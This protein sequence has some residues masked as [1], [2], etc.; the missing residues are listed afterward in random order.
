MSCKARSCRYEYQRRLAVV[1]PS[2]VRAA[3]LAAQAR[4]E[5]E[6]QALLNSVG[7]SNRNGPSSSSAGMQ[8]PDGDIELA[9]MEDFRVRALVRQLRPVQHVAVA[10]MLKGSGSGTGLKERL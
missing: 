9:P 10:R 3:E 8:R 2:A 1:N 6:R 5:R 4:S 7:V